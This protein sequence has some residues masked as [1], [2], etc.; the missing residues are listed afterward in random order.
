MRQLMIIMCLVASTFNLSAEETI[1]FSQVDSLIQTY[2]N[3]SKWDDLLNIGNKAHKQG[4][5]YKA[6]RQMMGYAYFMNERYD[7]AQQQYQK[8]L[9][10]DQSDETSKLM[11]YYCA[12]NGG[13]DVATRY[14]ESQLPADTKKILKVRSTKLL[15]AVDVEYNYKSNDSKIR[16]NSSYYRIG[17]NTQF[18]DRVSIYHAASYYKQGIVEGVTSLQSEY[19]VKANYILSPYST[20]DG[21]YHFMHTNVNKTP[22]V[23]QINDTLKGDFFYAKFSTRCSF[24]NCSLGASVFRLDTIGFFNRQ[25]GSKYY[26]QLDASIGF[27]IPKAKHFTFKS[28]ASY[29]FQLDDQLQPYASRWVMNQ[30]L[31]FVP[32]NSILFETNIT[33]G[34]LRNYHDSDGLYIYNALDATTFRVGGTL[35][36]NFIKSLTLFA[37]YGYEQKELINFDTSKQSYNQHSISGGIIWKL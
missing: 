4:I 8:S 5:D 26:N 14:Y 7:L 10:F 11:L 30:K 23:R 28:T 2:K 3:Q 34:N 24:L 25:M 13:D 37:N 12:L 22:D 27:S 16:T 35:F 19:Y 1:T 31:S 33:T 6:L 36:W 21:A 9:K 20:I 32:L 29:L 15:D 18:F 17:I